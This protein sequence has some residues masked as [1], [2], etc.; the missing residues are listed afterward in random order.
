MNSST[1]KKVNL[2]DKI[3]NAQDK[4]LE[5]I[6]EYIKQLN[7]SKANKISTSLEGIW[8]ECGFENIDNIEKELSKIRKEMEILIINKKPLDDSA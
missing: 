5:D 6:T 4:E 2:I 8:A 7:I 1:L 3:L